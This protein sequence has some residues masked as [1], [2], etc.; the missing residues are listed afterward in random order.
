[1]S[2]PNGADEPFLKDPNDGVANALQ[3]SKALQASLQAALSIGEHPCKT[4]EER[5]ALQ[6]V[7]RALIIT[8]RLTSKLDP[9]SAL[10]ICRSK[11]EHLQNKL[12]AFKRLES[13]EKVMCH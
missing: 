5:F 4:P 1:M 7:R 11:L 10:Y 13:E 8:T 3:T 9:L 2:R 12:S 6:A